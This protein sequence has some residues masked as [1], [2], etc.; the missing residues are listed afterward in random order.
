VNN[1]V[2]ADI[3]NTNETLDA[4]ALIEEAKWSM[5]QLKRF[6]VTGFD[7]APDTLEIL[8][9]WDRP[10]DSPKQRSTVESLEDIRADLGDCTRCKLH[11]GRKNIVFG[12]GDDTAR[13]VFV[14]E[15]PGAEE[16]RQ[17][18]P[19]VG[20]AGDLL[21]RIIDAMKLSRDTVYI[22]NIVKCRPPKNRNPEPD[23]IDTCIPFLKRQLTAIKPDLIVT[24]GK[25]AAHSLLGTD[26]YISRLRG[27]FH[28]WQG[29]P[30]MP[31]YHPAYL[32]RNP[33]HKR[34][35]WEDMKQVMRKG[36]LD[37]I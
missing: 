10:L 32:L 1:P 25:V 17:G 34:H 27:R 8:D 15:G 18:V 5:E 31:T 14:G 24:L 33:E 36:T 20:A 23:E 19:F 6:G 11:Q 9:G 22:C 13:L 26:T 12:A 35:V 16:D 3:L 21:T 7:L 37:L 2:P 30:V 29:I 28:D 4:M